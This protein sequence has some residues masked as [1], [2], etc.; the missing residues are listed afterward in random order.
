M[1]VESSVTTTWSI[2]SGDVVIRRGRPIVKVVLGHG[3]DAEVLDTGRDARVVAGGDLGD[4]RRAEDIVVCACSAAFADVLVMVDT[5]T[6]AIL[7]AGSVVVPECFLEVPWNGDGTGTLKIVSVNGHTSFFT[8]AFTVTSN[9]KVITVI[10][11]EIDSASKLNDEQNW[12][13]S[14]C[15]ELPGHDLAAK[16]I[17]DWV[18]SA[19]RQRR[20][21]NIVVD[22]GASG[23]GAS[24]LAKTLASLSLLPVQDLELS[25][26][27]S[28]KRGHA[29]ARLSSEFENARCKS[30]CF[31]IM[32]NVDI[33]AYSY[34]GRRLLWRLEQILENSQTDE[35]II[36]IIVPVCNSTSS[37]PVQLRRGLLLDFTVCLRNPDESSRELILS[38]M[39]RGSSSE[40]LIRKVAEKTYGFLPGDLQK[41]AAEAAFR[42][43]RK[44]SIAVDKSDWMLSLAAIRPASIDKKVKP[45]SPFRPLHAMAGIDDIICKLR[46]AIVNPL[47]APH[48]YRRLGICPPNGILLY[49]PSGVGKTTIALGIANEANGWLYV[50]LSNITGD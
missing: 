47:E 8:P 23:A 34:Q 17:I 14:I 49:G 32:E 39:I 1:D 33:L 24:T 13:K 27:L 50:G 16:R 36:F 28:S 43:I 12:H 5:T 9:T 26:L 4:L 44:S 25:Q 20:S 48:S 22:G 37:I 42:A 19:Y 6:L 2:R 35:R 11:S 46:L 41:L 3:S 29:E 21:C 10:Q 45:S 40:A 31:L 38:K 7:L 18:W 30:P 15:M